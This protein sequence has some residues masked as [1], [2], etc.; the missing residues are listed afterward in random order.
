V[1]EAPGPTVILGARVVDSAPLR[2]GFAH[3]TD[4]VTLDDGRRVVV[5]RFEGADGRRELVRSVAL[6]DR[7]HAAGIP[8]PAVLS[9]EPDR[10]PPVLV[11][12]FVDGTTGAEWLDSDGRARTLAQTMGSL[13]LRF[14]DLPVDDT[15]RNDGA[16][17]D[18]GRLAQAAT[19]WLATLAPRL[20]PQGAG[21]RTV[22]RI[23][24]VIATL[25]DF[26]DATDPALAHGDFVPVNV[27]L[28]GDGSLAAVLDLGSWRI[29]HPWLDV[30]WWGSVVQTF[31][32]EAWV[33]AWPVLASAAGVP[34][35]GDAAAALLRLQVLRS[36]ESA[37]TRNDPSALRLLHSAVGRQIEA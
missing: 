15:D 20:A 1:S 35:G 22:E 13:A 17:S 8:T 36:L 6:T 37:A 4:L 11:L 14:R 29:A 3:H 33:T 21:R 16:W 2:W 32:P 25:P 12:A 10:D 30:A 18:S 9:A 26:Y 24:D 31:H 27:L 5:K 7:L 34:D 28:A 19:G 23:R